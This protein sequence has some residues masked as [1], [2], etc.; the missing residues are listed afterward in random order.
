LRIGGESNEMNKSL[1]SLTLGLS[2]A[3]FFQC[4]NELVELV[5]QPGRDPERFFRITTETAPG[6]PSTST[7]SKAK[8][9]AMKTSV[10]DRSVRLQVNPSSSI[11]SSAV[12]FYTELDSAYGGHPWPEGV[13]QQSPVAFV[14]FFTGFYPASTGFS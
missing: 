11:H 4:V 14:N 12:H 10:R 8:A 7:S 1:M 2:I 5:R 6:L 9:K 13:P 3:S